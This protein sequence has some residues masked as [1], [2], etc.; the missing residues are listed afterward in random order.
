MTPSEIRRVVVAATPGPWTI[1]GWD[2][3]AGGTVIATLDPLDD[4]GPDQDQRQA[5]EDLLL[6]SRD[7][8]LDLLAQN[9]VLELALRECLEALS[10]GARRLGAIVAAEV[11]LGAQE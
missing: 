3:M 2:I 1:D 11:A 10:D 5:D 8:I 6:H 9:K 7:W 4:Y